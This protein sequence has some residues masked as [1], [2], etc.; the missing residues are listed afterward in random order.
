MRRSNLLININT[1]EGVEWPKL[2]SAHRMNLAQ[3]V[4]LPGK[5]EGVTSEETES[6]KAVGNSVQSSRT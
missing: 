2:K 4:P 5:I 1:V 6:L 3:L